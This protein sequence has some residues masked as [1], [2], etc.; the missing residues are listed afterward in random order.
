MKI[1][2]QKFRNVNLQLPQKIVVYRDGVSDSQFT[3]ILAIELAGMRAACKEIET[4][5]E[6]GFTIVI[7]QKRNRAQFPRLGG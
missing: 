1:Y 5:Y 6:P 3:E 2:F 4:N 7:V